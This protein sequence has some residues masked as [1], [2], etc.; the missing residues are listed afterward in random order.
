MESLECHP[1]C[2]FQTA[3]SPDPRPSDFYLFPKLKEFTKGWNLLT[4]RMLST[5]QVA[6]WRTKIKSSSTMGHSGLWINTVPA[7][8]L[9]TALPHG[10]AKC[11]SVGDNYVESDKTCTFSVVN[12][13]MPHTPEC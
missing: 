1:D 3:P 10:R 9:V 8:C 12:C 5:L 4:M 11:I 7:Y 6:D 2:W 13:V